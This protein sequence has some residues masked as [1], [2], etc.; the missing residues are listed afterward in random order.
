MKVILFGGSGM[1]G[2]GVLRECLLAEDVD[3]VLAIGRTQ[4]ALG[5]PKLRQIVRA[6]L[7]NYTEMEAELHGFDACFFTLGVSASEVDETGYARINR[8]LPILVATTLAR[9]NPSMVFTYVSGAGTDSTERGRVMWARVKGSTENALMRIPFKGAYMF[10]PGAIVPAHGEV[11]KTR[12]Y[13]WSYAALGWGLPLLRRAF[14]NFILTTEQ[15]GIAMLQ[16]VRVGSA[17]PILET[18]DI[19]NLAKCAN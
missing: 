16:T 13:R 8:D 5:H 3:E 12:A 1:I 6:D 2:Q 10:R 18:A 14:P 17:R 19:A 11:S 15:I 7:F 9:F 4:L